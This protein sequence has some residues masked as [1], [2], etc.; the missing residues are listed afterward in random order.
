[1]HILIAPDSFK[2]SAS[3]A[4]IGEVIKNAIFIEMPQSS[5]EVVPMAD[6][7]EGTIEV[8]LHDSRG[9]KEKILVNNAKG[10]I[11]ETYYGVLADSK[12]VIIE[13]ALITGF[14]SIP[15]QHR[16]PLELNTYGIGECII[17]AL[18]QGYRKFIFCLGG[19]ATN[20]GGIGMLQALGVNFQNER[21][22]NIPPHPIMM[23]S[24][25]K[26][27]YSNIDPRIFDSSILIASD[28]NNPLFG[29]NGATYV[30]GPQKGVLKDQL[31]SLDDK[32]KHYS[33]YIENHLEKEFHRVPGAGAAGGL[34]FALLTLGAKMRSG[35]EL[36]ANKLKINEKLAKSDWVITGEGK[37]DEQTLQGKLPF[38]IA[39]MAKEY[40]VPTILV[41]GALGGDLDH[42]YH[43]FDSVN[44]I[45]LG[46]LSL[47][48]SIERTEELL[49]HCIRNIARL[50]KAKNAL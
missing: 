1:M 15:L 20:D 10:E 28:V 30:F 39:S 36:I 25:Y 26:V 7:G 40:D 17:H 42:L 6:G 12:T 29:D 19:S 43:E 41:S 13:V 4:K 8:L 49:Y 14:N 27:D 47:E 5:V 33:M 18:D 34:G 2:G 45:A 37:T 32:I 50:L 38:V 31:Q 16:I 46:P 21:G 23:E 35:A 11:I 22:E 3:A 44:S 48:E 24:I 9:T